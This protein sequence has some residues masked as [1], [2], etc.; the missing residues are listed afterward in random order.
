MHVSLLDL[1]AMT[2]CS[3]LTS[4]SNLSVSSPIVITGPSTSSNRCLRF[5][6]FNNLIWPCGVLRAF[7]VTDAQKSWEA[8]TDA[9]AIS[10]RAN[11]GCVHWRDAKI[12]RFDLPNLAC[13]QP[14]IWCKTIRD[15]VVGLRH[16]PCPGFEELVVSGKILIRKTRAR[17]AD[18]L[19]LLRLRIVYGQQE[20]PIST[21]PLPLPVESANWNH[22]DAVARA[23]EVILLQLEPIERPLGGLI[24][25]ILAECLEHEPLTRTSNGVI[26][27]RLNLLLVE[28]LEI[29][30]SCELHFPGCLLQ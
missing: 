10:F 26:E 2:A 25:G 13:F 18:C 24:R 28:V 1:F 7:V 17:L 29:L 14:N 8:Q 3:T 12:S 20:G 27:E 23:I 9:F 22:I 5:K 16:G 11:G 6:H 19:V 4:K 21:S 30:T 15:I